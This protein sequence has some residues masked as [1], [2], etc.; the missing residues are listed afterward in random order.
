MRDFLVLRE[1]VQRL[2]G[3][4]AIRDSHSNHNVLPGSRDIL[5]YHVQRCD[6][7][8]S[9]DGPGKSVSLTSF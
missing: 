1:H 9:H 3:Q 2:H 8:Y 6:T 4:S 5:R 7:V